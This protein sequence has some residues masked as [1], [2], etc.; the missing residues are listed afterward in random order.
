MRESYIFKMTIRYKVEWLERKDKKELY[1]REK[2]CKHRVE[3]RMDEK[4]L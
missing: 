4:R 2:D 1:Q 3:R